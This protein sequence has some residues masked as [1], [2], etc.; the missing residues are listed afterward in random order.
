M[1]IVSNELIVV[2]PPKVLGNLRKAFH[3]EVADRIAAEI[4]KE[5]TS[6]PIPEIERHIAA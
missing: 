2:A 6:H 4:P 5:M 3:P 1:T